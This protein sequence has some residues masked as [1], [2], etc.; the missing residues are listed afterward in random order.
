MIDELC[1]FI[2]INCNLQ[3]PFDE[4]NEYNL[5]IYR[6]YIQ[7]Q[8][9]TK[10]IIKFD[11]LSLNSFNNV[12]S[13][14]KMKFYRN[15]IQPGTAVGPIAAQSI[16]EPCT[17]LSVVHNTIVYVQK[18]GKWMYTSIG[19]VI[20]EYMRQ[21]K[22][23]V[24]IQHITEDGN[25]S[26]VL[27]TTKLNLYTVGLNMCTNTME[28]KK[29]TQFSKHPLNGLLVRITTKSGKTVTA[30]AGHSFITKNKNNDSI[31]I[32]RGDQLQ[33]GDVMPIYTTE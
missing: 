6:Y 1:K 18:C 32:I 17:Q 25:A 13:T 26:Y 22:D 20:D 12:I 27:N 4:M 23:N 2:K 3:F 5:R 11:K 9:A 24:I 15:L 31:R 14:I 10:K 33:I 7:S 21:Y 8:L 19:D 28:K 29:I 30:T 16:G